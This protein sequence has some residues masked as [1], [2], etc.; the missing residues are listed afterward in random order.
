MK[1][2]VQFKQASNA[3]IDDAILGGDEAEKRFKFMSM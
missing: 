3:A 1:D 2:V